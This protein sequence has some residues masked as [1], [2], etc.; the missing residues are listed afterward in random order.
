MKPFTLRPAKPKTGASGGVTKT[1]PMSLTRAG[2]AVFL[3]GWLVLTAV[4]LFGYHA[5]QGPL[6]RMQRARTAATAEALADRVSNRLAYIQATLAAVAG[7]PALAQALKAGDK[8]RQ[9]RQL[10]RLKRLFPSARQ[11]RLLAPVASLSPDGKSLS[12]AAVDMLQ[13]AAQ[14]KAPVEVDF[15]GQAAQQVNLAQA[16]RGNGKGRVV[17]NIMVSFPT[18]LIHDLLK[19]DATHG[20]YLELRQIPGQGAP[21]KL[22]AVGSAAARQGTPTASVPIG[23]SRW[24]LAYWAR[25]D[26]GFGAA[27]THIAVAYGVAAVLWALAVLVLFRWLVAALRTDLATAVGLVKGSQTG[28]LPQPY[29]AHLE[30]CR[31][32]L[33]MLRHLTATRKSRAAPPVDAA[34][35]PAS[36]EANSD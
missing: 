13:Q 26:A 22:T 16:V 32:T 4:A 29:N 10:A 11:I 9:R 36:G 2:V 28:V 24:Q 15:P 12:Y 8:A 30:D 3:A 7:D 35:G 5:A 17:G 14:G 19:G 6:E 20:G 27:V 33:D 25:N 31:G 18:S 1:V 34:V 23:G 21:V